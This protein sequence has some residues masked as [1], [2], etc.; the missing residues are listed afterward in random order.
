MCCFPFAHI[1]GTLS[2]TG[3]LQ[4]ERGWERTRSG[5]LLRLSKLKGRGLR[6]HIP[7]REATRRSQMDT[8]GL[9]GLSMRLAL[10]IYSPERALALKA[11]TRRH[12]DHVFE[13]RSFGVQRGAGRAGLNTKG[14]A[15]T[16][17]AT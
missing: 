8:R 14:P 7:R 16:L 5:R 13:T 2:H 9:L 4:F 17:A 12:P 10:P 3:S 6:A 11:A 1:L 15:R